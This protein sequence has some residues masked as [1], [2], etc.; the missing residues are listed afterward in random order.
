MSDSP[1]ITPP[2]HVHNIGFLQWALC[3]PIRIFLYVHKVNILTS[4]SGQADA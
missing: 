1:T 4:D 2:P 3:L